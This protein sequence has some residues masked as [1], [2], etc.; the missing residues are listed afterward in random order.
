MV[1][2]KGTN[3]KTKEPM[4][5][6]PFKLPPSFKDIACYPT[7]VEARHFAATYALFRVCSM[8]NIHMMLPPLYRDIWKIQLQNLKIDDMKGGRGWMYEADPFTAQI[9]REEARA[10]MEKQR[11]ERE[12]QKDKE[13]EQDTNLTLSNS[14]GGG[15]SRNAGKTSTKA[16]IVDMGKRMRAS[17]EDIVRRNGVWNPY[18]TS[19]TDDQRRHIVDALAALGFRQS[20][21]EEGAE[22]CGSQEETLEWLLIHV[23][24]DDLPRW[25][26]PGNYAAGVSMASGNMKRESSIKRLTKAGYSAEI[27]GLTLDEYNGNETQ[28]A[29]TLQKRIVGGN[30][31]QNQE[32]E[33]DISTPAMRDSEESVWSEEMSTLEAIFGPRFSLDSFDTCHIDLQVPKASYPFTLYLRKSKAYPAKPPVLCVTAQ[34]LPA[35]IRLSI[36]RQ[37]VER[38]QLDMLGQPLIFTLVDWLENEIMGIVERPGRLRDIASGTS[39]SAVEPTPTARGLQRYSKAPRG[40]NWHPGSGKSLELLERW[41]IRQRDPQQ[42][43]KMAKRHELPAWAL[44]NAIVGTVSAKQVTII[45]GETGSGK[46]T[47]A[48]QFILDD[49]IR[50]K[51]GEAAN[52]VCTQPRRISALG[53]AERV[54]EERC[55]PVGDEVGYAIRG[56][57]RQR[58]GTTK[59]TFVTTGVLLRRLQT[60]GGT[61][62][63]VVAALADV[64]H[65]VI[66]EVHERNLDI[67]FLLIILRE[68]LRKRKDIKVILMSATLDASVFESYFKASSSVGRIEIQGRTHPVDDFYLDDILRLTGFSAGQANGKCDQEDIEWDKEDPSIAKTIQILGMKISYEL[69]AST[70]RAID[71]ELRAREGGI[72]IFVPG[73]L[74]INRT[75]DAVGRLP[76]IHALP[77]HASLTPA[78]QRRVFPPAPI[79][80]RKVIVATNVAETSITIED[81]VAVID[82]GKVKETNF[83]PSSNMIKL[84][85]VWASQAACKQR[86]GRAGRV[87]AGKCYKLY[88]RNAEARMAER[89][90]P[91]IRRVPLEQLCLSVRAMGIKDVAAFLSNALT[92]PESL[93]IQGALDLLR[94]IGALDGDELTALGRHLSVIPADLRCGKLMVYGAT[95]GCLEAC[96]TIAAILTVRSPFTS[97]KDKRDESKAARA[98]FAPDQGDLLCDLRA[99]ERWAEM[100]NSASFR[101][102]RFWCD[103]H[104]LSTQTLKDISSNRIQYASSLTDAGFL[105]SNYGSGMTYALNRH[106]ANSALLRA[107]VA[108]AFN[109]QVARID[110]P[111]KKFAPSMSG[112]V[113]LDPEART[114][115]FFNQ[116][117]GRVFVHPSS[118]LFGAQSFAGGSA[119]MS[120]F[121]K[122]ATSKIFIRELSRKWQLHSH[123]RQLANITRLLAFNVYTA[124]LFSGPIT[125][126]TLGRGLIVDGWLRLRGW[127]RIGVLVSRLRFMLD[128]VLARK[129]DHP[130]LDLGNDEVVIIVRRLIEKDGFDQ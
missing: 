28:A 67:D 50:R 45:S 115:K 46:S 105:P 48:V 12:R 14:S 114:I 122:M 70:V 108:G 33:S 4:V 120:Y 60:S 13:A 97:P 53:L 34:T 82:L 66:D 31:S 121:N 94:R 10:L 93:T 22:T 68:V 36:I 92:P 59:I 54:S 6:P 35:Y 119:Y 15:P 73:T 96:L 84:E 79:G 29:E 128:E 57:S 90:E 71:A 88:T 16:P 123:W 85:E 107:L 51:V 58:S 62:E 102:V 9:E 86:R 20:H 127:A 49:M 38:V 19:L 18:K 25:A 52:I 116:E 47:Q 95:F 55:S 99:Y 101:D 42:Q 2:L 104:F 111:D 21:A 27:C 76:S 64:S 112:A 72:L 125:V 87:Q 43:S 37:A 110:F 32:D 118:T 106:N 7:A 126:D 89:P 44:Q 75:I 98:A 130:A 30:P 26:L 113:E 65:V 103:E 39:A 11:L 8:K 1:I 83:D 100:N 56:E 3:P 109:P 69:I 5:L 78:E 61:T 91:E 23:P 124:L 129:I 117:N 81:I 17:V 41:T 80:K 40:L 77:L 63:R 24:E 74:E